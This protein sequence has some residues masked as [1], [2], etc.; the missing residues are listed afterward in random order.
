MCGTPEKYGTG[1]ITTLL[2]GKVVTIEG[3][4][5][6]QIAV[7]GLPSGIKINFDVSP[8]PAS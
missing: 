7:L 1:F 5:I 4:F 8:S 6:H 3:Y 2:I